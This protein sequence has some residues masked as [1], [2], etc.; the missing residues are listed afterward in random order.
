MENLDPELINRA[1]RGN[2]QAFSQLIS[3]SYDFIYRVSYQWMGNEADAEDLTQ[4]VC[5]KLAKI[6]KKFRG[7]SQFSTWLY[8]VIIN[9]AKDLLRKKS[10][11][12][13]LT[14][15]DP[16]I[17]ENVASDS[18]QD[19]DE[20]AEELW[21]AVAKLPEKQRDTIRLVYQEGL[22]HSEVAQILNCA[23]KTVSWYI[24]EAKK[25]LKNYLS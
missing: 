3:E 14:H 8:R 18:T 21:N 12:P 22:N 13:K 5:I 20:E 16:E 25:S 1:K 17:S 2:R 24:H 9:Q 7:D 6:L 10:R 15:F 19:K 11:R 23:E 4:E